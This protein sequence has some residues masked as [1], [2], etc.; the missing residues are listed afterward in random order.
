MITIEISDNNAL[1]LP[2]FSGERKL[3]SAR[4][5]GLAAAI[6]ICEGW[7]MKAAATAAWSELAEPLA[8]KNYRELVAKRDVVIAESDPDDPRPMYGGE[9]GAA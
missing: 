2:R 6:G 1:V 7:S 5:R 8:A 9:A 3:T 4:P